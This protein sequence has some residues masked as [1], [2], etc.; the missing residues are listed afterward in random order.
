MGLG[1]LCAWES[2]RQNGRSYYCATLALP[3]ASTRTVT[4]TRAAKRIDDRT[5]LL[6]YNQRLIKG[7]LSL[8]GNLGTDLAQR[9]LVLGQR[10]GEGRRQR[11]RFQRVIQSLQG[12]ERHRHLG[13][14]I[15]QHLINA[16]RAPFL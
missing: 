13:G 7:R 2:R 11:L 10:L 15:V 6:R 8:G 3:T 16:I 14:E 9:R 12:I 4:S 5:G 1:R